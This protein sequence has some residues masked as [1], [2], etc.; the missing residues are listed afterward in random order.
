MTCEKG[1]EYKESEMVTR[2][3]IKSLIQLILFLIWFTE[4]VIKTKIH[5]LNS[6]TGCHPSEEGVGTKRVN[7]IRE[8]SFQ[9]YLIQLILCLIWSNEPIKEYF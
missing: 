2:N 6:Q 8:I 1:G 9:K 5:L 7:S 4:P 3:F